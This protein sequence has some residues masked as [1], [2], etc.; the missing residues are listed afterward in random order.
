VTSVAAASRARALIALAVGGLLLAGPVAAPAGATTTYRYWSYWIG[1]DTTGSS[2]TWGY[3]IEGAGTR[4]PSDGDVEGW[5]FGLAGQTSDI[6][7]S[8]IPEFATICADVEASEETK[9]VALVVDPGDAAE[10]PVGESPGE[11]ISACVQIEN[12]ATGLEILASV[13]EIRLDAG[14]VCGID[15]YPA[16]ECAPLVDDTETVQTAPAPVDTETPEA[17]EVAEATSE[18]P[19]NSGTPLITAVAISAL[20]LVGFW[21]WRRSRRQA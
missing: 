21:L 14:F 8:A 3:A 20:A 12:S 17:A 7:P 18:E 15:G 13:T 5:R 9:R 16:S 1:T 19:S 4:V 6:Y 11:P 10:A 2:P